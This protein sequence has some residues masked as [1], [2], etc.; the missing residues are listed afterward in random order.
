MKRSFIKAATPALAVG[1]A[2]SAQAATASASVSTHT[3]TQSL[4]TVQGQ[5]TVIDKKL[6]DI[7]A[8]LAK[9]RVISE[10]TRVRSLSRL[11]SLLYQTNT[12]SQKVNALAQ[13]L[14]GG[15]IQTT[16]AETKLNTAAARILEVRDALFIP[17]RDDLAN[18]ED[19]PEEVM[20]GN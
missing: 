1:L 20:D 11:N 12:A 14:G 4:K 18:T 17:D 3:E 6:E 16:D 2:F 15:T 8:D 13:Q 5:I 10:E 9:E 7:H 19:V